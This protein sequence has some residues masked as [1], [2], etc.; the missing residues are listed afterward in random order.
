MRNV[1]IKPTFCDRRYRR[2]T[3]TINCNNRTILTTVTSTPAVV[4]SWLHRVIISFSRHL[5]TGRLVVGLGVQW[6]ENS[7][8]AAT[9]QLC[10]GRFCLIL[11]LLYTTRIPLCLRRFLSNPSI[12]FVGVWNSRDREML[13]QSRHVIDIDHLIDVRH[14]AAEKRGI[15]SQVSMERLAEMILGMDGLDKPEEIGRSNWNVSLLSH[16]QVVYA[17]VDAFVSFCLGR[18]LDAWDWNRYRNKNQGAFA[19]HAVCFVA[20]AA[21]MD[22]QYSSDD[23][24]AAVEDEDHQ[25]HYDEDCGSYF[26]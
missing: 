19:G 22:P 21:P 9:L 23:E 26:M 12:T 7:S 6:R 3:F 1:R 2:R 25:Y 13:S 15:A 8:T 17:C 18:D 20:Q 14:V 11:Q 10:V 24:I 16:K 4:R 5:H